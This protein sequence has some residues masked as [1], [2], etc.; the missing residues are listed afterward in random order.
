VRVLG[1]TTAGAGHFAGLLPFARAGAQ[2]GH[3]VRVAAPPSFAGAVEDAGFVHEPLADADP[4][5]LGA[6]FGRVPTLSMR[7]ADDLVVQEVFGRV[8]R[9]AALPGMRAAL[10]RWRPHVV[11]REPA[12]LASYVAAHERGIPHVQTQIGPSAIDDRLLPLLAVPLHEIGCESAALRAA[13]R[14][15]IVPPSFDAPSCGTGLVTYARDPAVDLAT[16]A[17]MATLPDWWRPHDNDKPLVYVTFGSV[18]AS[19]GLFPKFYTRVVEQ[20][21]EL[22]ARVLLTLGNSGNPRGPRN[23]ATA[24]ARGAVVAAARCHACCRRHRRPRR[25]RN[26]AEHARGG[27]ATGRAAAVLL[28]PISGSPVVSVGPV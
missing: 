16:T 20:L 7:E 21:A 22:P 4:A 28:R 14:W 1:A 18:A 24:R 5:E 27:G 8:D 12:E 23:A 26:D 10:D 11:L 19:I 2:A 9:D 3:E 17:T 25:V 15:T 13:P 6:V